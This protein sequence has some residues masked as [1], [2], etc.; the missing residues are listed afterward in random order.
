MWD[1]GKKIFIGEPGIWQCRIHGFGDQIVPVSTIQ[2]RNSNH[3]LALEW[4]MENE[5]RIVPWPK[6]IQV[7]DEEVLV[8][9]KAKGIYKPKWLDC[10][11]S[12]RQN[13]DSIYP[14]EDP[15]KLHGESKEFRYYQEDMDPENFNKN[16]TNVAMKINIDN[17]LPIGVLRQVSKKPNSRYKVMG[18]AKVIGWENGYFTL[19]NISSEVYAKEIKSKK[20]VPRNTNSKEQIATEIASNLGISAPIMSAGST[21]PRSF[22]ADVACEL[23]IGGIEDLTKTRIV[24][25]ILTHLGQLNHIPLCTA[26]STITTEVLHVVR[27]GVVTMDEINEDDNGDEQD[28]DMEGALSLDINERP[29]L[30]AGTKSVKKLLREMKNGTIIIPKFQRNFIWSVAK[31]RAL[32]ESILLGIPLPSIVLIEEAETEKMMLVDGLQRM[33]TLQQFIDDEIH[34]GTLDSSSISPL[35]EKRFS[36]LPDDFQKTILSCTMAFTEI[37]GMTNREILYELFRRYNTGGVNLNAAEIRNAVYHDNLAHKMLITLAGEAPG[38][39]S[40]DM[41]TETKKLRER[42]G[43][44]NTIHER[45]RFKVYNFLCRYFGYSRGS[46][47]T[48]TAKG[49]VEFMKQNENATQTEINLLKNEIIEVANKNARLFARY[50]FKKISQNGDPMSFA[51]WPFTIQMV[52]TKYL[53]D[54]GKLNS[55]NPEKIRVAWKEFYSNNVFGERQN[56]GTLWSSQEKWIEILADI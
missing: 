25:K 23:R 27:E 13:M 55:V 3:Q 15:E 39:T 11:L 8:A 19:R 7:D 5:G 33:K 34:L 31:Q 49:I 30:S 46:R 22:F 44:S 41:S 4:F 10:V 38:A 24:E 29:E 6:P 1:E 54:E 21:I 50:A 43:F 20:I 45:N 47:G 36:E 32:I 26:G 9:T 17:S 2:Y 48:T 12:I 37:E 16:Y 40:A 52:G 56:S 35:S 14:D 53:Q 28:N 42:L 18:L 51:A